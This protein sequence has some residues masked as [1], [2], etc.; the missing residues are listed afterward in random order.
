MP[1]WQRF[2]MPSTHSPSFTAGSKIRQIILPVVAVALV[3]TLT[4]LGTS[5]AF[6]A[7]PVQ[8][9][10]P[11]D[12][13]VKANAFGGNEGYRSTVVGHS[14]PSHGDLS[15]SSNGDYQ[16]TPAA[17]FT[18]KD[19]FSVS[20]S[21]AL[22]LFSTQLPALENFSGTNI[23]A[24]GYGSSVVAVPGKPG[25][26]YGLT[27]R[28]PNVDGPE[29]N[30][31][32]EAIA[33]FTPSI[34]EFQL[35][36]GQATLIR[37]IPLKAADGTPMNG[38]VNTS[39]STGE[40]IRDLNGN[41]LPASAN[42]LDSEGLVAMA[43][44]TFYV[45]DEYGPF[46]V[47]F[48]ADGREIGRMSPFGAGL[49]AKLANRTPNQGMEGLTITPDGS[50]LVG[51]MQ[52]GLNQPDLAKGVSA[53]KVAPTRIVT[54]GLNDQSVHEYLVMLENPG[55]TKD[56]V[57]EITALSATEFLIDERD[58]LMQPGGRKLFYNVDLKDA[59]DVGPAATV[60]GTSYDGA[61]GGLLIAGKTIEVT[62]GESTTEAAT[63]TLAAAGIK[64][65]A[66][67]LTLDLG[68]LVTSLNPSG[69]FF[70]HDKIEGVFPLDGG[71]KL[72]I[73]NDNDFGIDA[74]FDGSKNP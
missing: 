17:G 2:S 28:G 59:T 64:A 60:A 66:K 6:A 30:L 21:D 19:S 54:I 37:N 41:V 71:R 10:T 57:S 35:I 52:S 16:Y 42:G 61:K 9:S 31:K 51:I 63:A 65:A 25:F 53:K 26:I 56:A 27:D 62:V 33:D 7:S 36:D 49:P 23:T 20:S 12:T 73:S 13:A 67:K 1:R 8:V 46:I 40:T 44:G 4:T 22:Q 69:A 15:I 24:G 5:T 29:K 68:A 39:A 58:G 45:S 72:L 11:Q 32:I 3:A 70:G 43:D 14:Q 48:A 34:G 18:G 55:S 50:T 47:H 38:Q 74:V